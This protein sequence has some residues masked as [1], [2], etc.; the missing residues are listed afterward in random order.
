LENS[1]KM[2]VFTFEVMELLIFSIITV[3]YSLIK[4]SWVGILISGI[5]LFPDAFS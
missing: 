1:I 3:V 4:R 2:A 5:L